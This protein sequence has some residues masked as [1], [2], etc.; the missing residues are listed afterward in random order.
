MLA[1]MRL[2]SMTSL[3]G[4]KFV[5]VSWALA[6][7]SAMARKVKM[8]APSPPSEACASYPLTKLV[9]LVDPTKV[10]PLSPNSVVGVDAAL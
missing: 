5:I 6:V 8:F 7:E 4:S 1:S 10:V 9:S 2:R 3:A